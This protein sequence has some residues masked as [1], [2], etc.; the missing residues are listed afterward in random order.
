MHENLYFQKY[1]FIISFLRNFLFDLRK[2]SKNMTMPIY[3]TQ[4]AKRFYT[5]SAIEGISS[6]VRKINNNPPR[7]CIPGTRAL[8][9]L[10][11]KEKIFFAVDKFRQKEM[12]FSEVRSG[13]LTYLK[14]PVDTKIIQII[15]DCIPFST[16]GTC[17]AREAICSILEDPNQLLLWGYTGSQKDNGQRLDI[18]QLLNEWVDSCDTRSSRV[19]ANILDID[20]I[21]ALKEWNCLA[22]KTAK[23]FY[24]VYGGAKFGEDIDSSDFITDRACCF[25]GGIQSFRQMTNLLMRSTS[26]RCYYGLRMSND[27][28]NFDRNAQSYIEYF[29]AVEFMKWMRDKIQKYYEDNDLTG[30]TILPQ[31]DICDDILEIWKDSYLDLHPLCNPQVR[32]FSTRQ[33][34]FQGGWNLFLEKKL[35][36]KLHLC[37]FS[38]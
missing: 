29:S 31:M 33:A 34:L 21:K 1:L 37:N 2:D 35:W 24:L 12:D 3:A 36:K 13:I 11:E 8:A 15:G 30:K 7:W 23:N 19:L 38:T 9:L 17:K 22:A 4:F 20:T 25:D 6:V 14:L 26:I 16:T 10:L 28:A 27:P 5:S 18:N 32:D